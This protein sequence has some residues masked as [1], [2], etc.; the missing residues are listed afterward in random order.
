M[1]FGKFVLLLV[2][3]I[4]VCL[5]FAAILTP[6]DSTPD[7]KK[8]S[9]ES[10][11]EGDGTPPTAIVHLGDD[12]VRGIPSTAVI[13]LPAGE[14]FVDGHLTLQGV[15]VNLVTRPA[16]P[17]DIARSYTLYSVAVGGRIARAEV[18]EQD[19]EIFLHSLRNAP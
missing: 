3:A 9:H 19:F 11:S 17:G 7:Q 13:I 5:V 1:K 15:L 12:W 8:P 6:N 14:K 16:A 18:K 4:A 10:W 2:F